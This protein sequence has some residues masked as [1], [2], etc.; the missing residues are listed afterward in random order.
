MLTNDAGAIRCEPSHSKVVEDPIFYTF[1][2]EVKW[3]PKGYEIT[4]VQV[5]G[6]IE[7]ERT[8]NNLA[9]MKSKLRNKLTTHLDFCARMFNQNF[10]NVVI[11]VS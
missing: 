9:F 7:D 4:M 8:F 10:Y 11:F 1:G 3:V 6:S 5:L 2:F